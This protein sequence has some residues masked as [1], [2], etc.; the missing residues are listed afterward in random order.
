MRYLALFVALMG[1][2]G[3]ASAQ[4]SERIP[5]IY[6]NQYEY[7]ADVS[8]PVEYV[9]DLSATPRPGYRVCT[10]GNIANCPQ[11]SVWYANIPGRCQKCVCD[12]AQGSLYVAHCN[13]VDCDT[14]PERSPIPGTGILKERRLRQNCGRRKRRS[15]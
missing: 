7:R 2:A 12:T 5:T 14:L 9:E 1:L 13:K 15:A 6:R 3:F 8:C 11:G 4:G 10:K